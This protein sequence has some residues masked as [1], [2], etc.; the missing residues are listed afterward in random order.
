MPLF[1]RYLLKNYLKVFFLAVF[2]F[3]AILLVSRLTEI[4]HFATMGAR[5]L[6][7]TLFVLYQVPYILPI[8]IPLSCLI[9]AMILFQRLSHT[10]ELVALR[11]GGFSL[12]TTLAPL[13]LVAAFLSLG[14]FYIVSEMATSSHMATRKMVHDLTSVNPLLLLQNAKIAK[15][16]GAYVQMEPIKNGESANDLLIAVT[17]SGPTSRM[18]LFLAKRVEMNHNSLQGD[19][20][21]LISS[22]ASS[23]P[24][25]FDHL[26][27]ENQKKSLSAA[28]E[29]AK[30]LRKQGWKVANDHLTFSLLRIRKQELAS[31]KLESPQFTRL[32]EK[33]RSEM[34]RRF[35]LGISVFTFTLMGAAFGMEIS[36]H[37]TKRGLF[38]VGGL[39]AL[40]LIAFFVGK[41]LGH[42][43]WVAF[44]F[45]FLPQFAILLAS[46]WTLRRV[47]RGV[48]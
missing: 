37:Q 13:L 44:S 47:T 16:Q 34:A 41:A 38:W 29:F 35:A 9:S 11:A 20:V 25:A 8:A 30:L 40:T 42:L 6:Y 33:C 36:R 26:I 24:Q 32:Y 5:P 21:T 1:A 45:Y 14:N 43:F 23:N 15:L 12:K 7:L 19:E 46:V 10:R 4:A 31:Q 28:S 2:S 17:G 22:M 39:T 18:A 48:E 27:I 3:I